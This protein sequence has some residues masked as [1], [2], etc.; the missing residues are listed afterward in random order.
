MWLDKIRFAPVGGG[1]SNRVSSNPTGPAVV[2]AGSV[3]DLGVNVEQ[4][5][6]ASAAISEGR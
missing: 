2:L 1:P 5:P 4:E 6:T 3:W